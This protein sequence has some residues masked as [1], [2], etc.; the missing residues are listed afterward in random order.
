[1]TSSTAI[2]R[3]KCSGQSTGCFGHERAHPGFAA[4]EPLGQL[5]RGRSIDCGRRVVGQVGVVGVDRR[6][7]RF[8]PAAVLTSAIVPVS[9][10]RRSGPTRSPLDAER[11]A[12]VRAERDFVA[13]ELG[14]GLGKGG[15]PRT[16]ATDPERAPISVTRA[17]GAAI[18]RIGRV[19]AAAEP[20]WPAPSAPARSAPTTPNAPNSRQLRPCG[21]W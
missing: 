12:R 13:H 20:T 10:T 2:P 17:L 16:L 7:T 15:R 3:S 11:A 14:A 5:V 8:E 18:D 9:G 21:L 19:D 4:G 1:M 6:C